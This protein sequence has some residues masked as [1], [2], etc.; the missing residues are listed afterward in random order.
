MTATDVYNDKTSDLL[1]FAT[2]SHKIYSW[3][4][5][6]AVPT[7]IGSHNQNITAF[8]LP[9]PLL[10]NTQPVV[11]T[12]VPPELRFADVTGAIYSISLELLAELPNAVQ[13]LSELQGASP[14]PRGVASVG[15]ILYRDVEAGYA[16]N[17]VLDAAVLSVPSLRSITAVLIAASG[18]PLKGG[19]AEV[20]N[21]M[22]WGGTSVDP[23]NGTAW[24]FRLQMAPENEQTAYRGLSPRRNPIP[25]KPV[26]F[27]LKETTL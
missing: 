26:G 1:F 19:Q 21:E 25:F 13:A 16:P 18:D 5:V 15:K 17:R 4:N 11:G 22:L 10:T 6:N 20:L 23:A 3:K 7:L 12:V 8:L 24:W 9:K 14:I 27:A 2:A